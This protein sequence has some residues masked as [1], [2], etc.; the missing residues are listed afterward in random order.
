MF[1]DQ[2]ILCCRQDK[3][4]E[5]GIVVTGLQVIQTCFFVKVVTAVAE[6]VESSYSVGILQYLYITPSVIDVFYNKS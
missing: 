5:F 4:T 1:R 6:R 2:G 3:A